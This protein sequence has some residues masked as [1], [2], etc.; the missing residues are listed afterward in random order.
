MN[1]GLSSQL[2]SEPK[3]ARV[4]VDSTQRRVLF[5]CVALLGDCKRWK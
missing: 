2:E 4:S 3:T 1:P 5:F